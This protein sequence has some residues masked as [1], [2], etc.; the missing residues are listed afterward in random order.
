MAAGGVQRPHQVVRQGGAT[1][2]CHYDSP[3]DL[4]PLPHSSNLV[5]GVLLEIGD[6]IG[7]HL[8]GP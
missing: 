5:I 1:E 8:P 4:I 6:G 7:T 3:D 2:K